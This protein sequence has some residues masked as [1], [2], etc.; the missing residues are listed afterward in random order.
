MSPIL[1][2]PPQHRRELPEILAIPRPASGPS[3]AFPPEI[4]RDLPMATLLLIDDNETIREGLA[5]IA[6]KMGHAALTA[7]SGRAGL[8][9]LRRS[10]GVDFLI[11]DLKMDG[12]DG[13]EVVR[14]AREIDPDLPAMIITAFGTVETAVEAMKLGCFD[15]L[16]KPFAPEV[17]RFKIERALELR[18]AR[19][20]R[21]RLQAENEL[22]RAMEGEAGRGGEELLGSTPE[23]KRV[24]GLIER[25][26][27]S[28]ASVAITG[29]S[30][31]GKEL[32]AR[33]IH[34]KSKRADRAF[35]KVS[36]AALAETLLESELF[37]HERGAFTGAAGPRKGKLAAAD[38]GTVFLDEIGELPLHLQGR[39]LRF[40]QTGEIQRVGRDLP[41]EVSARVIAATNRDLAGDAA[42]GAFRTDLYHRLSC[43][44]LR[45]P[46]LRERGDDVV[47]LARAFLGRFAAEFGLPELE[48]GPTAIALL[49]QWPWPGNVRELQNVVEQAI[50]L[51][52]GPVLDVADLQPMLAADDNHSAD[53]GPGDAAGDRLYELL[54]SGSY[55]FWEHVH[56]QFLA[57][58]ITRAQVRQ[59]V[60]RA[61]VSTKGNYRAVL[62]LLG[63]A[64]ED[65]KRFLNFLS[66][67]DCSLDVRP[68]RAGHAM[69]PS[70]GSTAGSGRSVDHSAS[71]EGATGSASDLHP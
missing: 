2:C 32:V 16:Q 63:I 18:A 31:T 48:L 33:A 3:L 55:T 64:D 54:T 22:L 45:L 28:D 67:H 21:G 7:S 12:L 66:A 11:T 44:K 59:V 41:I 58:D 61:L 19:R 24:L 53:D 14:Q 26:A 46:A 50:W 69:P 37:G 8:E 4:E 62:P 23:M 65:Y 56:P 42:A 30:G 47:S 60:H 6:R 57:R 1:P 13:V 10:G 15:F 40:L 20:E 29:E 38:G 27:A 52:A 71:G 70:P 43:V 35:V 68:Y 51:A 17:V 34:A 36:C 5:H 39:L 9:L 49:R 25:V